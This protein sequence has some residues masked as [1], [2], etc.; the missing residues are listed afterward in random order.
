M[1][2]TDAKTSKKLAAE[3][4]RAIDFLTVIGTH[5]KRERRHFDDAVVTHCIRLI[6]EYV[7][8]LSKDLPSG[9]NHGTNQKDEG[10]VP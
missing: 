7:D 9:G 8:E 5:L 4:E 2:Q 6:H 10:S 3:S 1:G